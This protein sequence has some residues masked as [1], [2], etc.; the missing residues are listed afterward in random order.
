[1]S[2]LNQQETHGDQIKG[3]MIQS[4]QGIQYQ[5]SRYREKLEQL[6]YNR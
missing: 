1:M 2:M 3:M 4:D 6:S 5:N